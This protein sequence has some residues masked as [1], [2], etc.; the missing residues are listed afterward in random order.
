MFSQNLVALQTI[1]RKEVNRF[2]RIWTQTLLPPIITQSLYFLIFGSFIGSRI[3][4]EGGIS[5]IQFVVPGLV[6]MAVI[7]ASFNNVV[8][9]FF[10][11]KFQRNLEEMQV[12]P[13]PNWVIISGYSIG[14]ILRGLIVGFIVFIV[15]FAFTSPSIH[16]PLYI[17]VYV[18][19]TSTI[20]ALGGLINGIFAKKFD[21][22]SIFNNFIL[23]P[24]TYLGGVF[25][26]IDRL[27]DIPNGQI[28]Y[29]LSRLNPI[30]Y[31]ID[32]FRYG[33]YGTNDFSLWQSFLILSSFLLILSIASFV[34]LKKGY[35]MKS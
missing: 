23:T 9:S 26:S 1:I 31:M 11:S 17:F 18:L 28:W 6:M 32:G 22:V 15:S 16:N 29:T 19:L 20:F 7:N 33:F 2:M 3:G 30:V 35:G 5:Y 25:Y 34:L 8:S 24:L 13:V 12:A 21:D 27:Q 14:G 4:D 10:G